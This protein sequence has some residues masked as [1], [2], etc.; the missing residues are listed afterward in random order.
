MQSVSDVFISVAADD[1]RRDL[2]DDGI[3]SFCACGSELVRGGIEDYAAV[4]KWKHVDSS[5][6]CRSVDPA[7][8]LAVLPG[9][10]EKERS[11][12]VG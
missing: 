1:M 4:L 10:A 3:R 9:Y 11:G 2:P 7:V 6:S 12:M 5:D 8:W